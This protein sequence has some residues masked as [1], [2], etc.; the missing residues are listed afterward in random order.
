MTCNLGEVLVSQE[1]TFPSYISKCENDAAKIS[2][3]FD[4]TVNRYK[5]KLEHL[6]SR[7]FSDYSSNLSNYFG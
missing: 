1:N 3:L 2:F 7:M 4:I 5:R 6:G